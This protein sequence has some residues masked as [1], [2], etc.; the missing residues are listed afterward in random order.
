VNGLVLLHARNMRKNSTK[1]EEY[2]WEYL[3]FDQLGVRFRRQHPLRG[4]ILDFYCDKARLGIEIDGSIHEDP[5]QQEKD[6]IRTDE[7]EN[8]RIEIIRFKNE[9][10]VNDIENVL[11]QIRMYLYPP[12]PSGE[13]LGVGEV[14]N[15]H[16]WLTKTQN[17]LFTLGADL[18]TPHKNNNAVVPRIGQS[19]IEE[20]E[21]W[22]S[23]LEQTPLP[24]YFVLPGGSKVAAELHMARAICRRAERLAVSLS[25][26]SAIGPEILQYL[27]RLSDF[28]FLA[29]LEANRG[30]N[31]E[32]IRVSYS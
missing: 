21:T 27:N 24:P 12:P 23:E 3:R 11:G 30:A 25:H 9:D 17:V 19:Q 2:L 18:A 5:I 14:T 22:V 28:L 20:L 10:I 29:S 4:R 7:L 1:A 8:E 32:N 26:Q 16:T 6:A 13:G 31:L 15:L